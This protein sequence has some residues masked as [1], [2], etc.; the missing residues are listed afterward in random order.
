VSAAQLYRVYLLDSRDHISG[1][2]ELICTADDV[3]CALAREIGHSGAMEIWCGAR[4]VA[5]A[6]G[7]LT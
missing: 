6:L 1:V 3:A 2:E 5:L 7:Q 4:L